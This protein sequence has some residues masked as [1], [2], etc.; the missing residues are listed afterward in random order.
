MRI[1]AYNNIAQVYKANKPVKTNRAQAASGKDEVT[2]SR[3]GRDFQ[4]AKQ[5]VSEAPDIREDKV[6]EAKAK[7]QSGTYDVSSSDFASKLMEKMAQFS[8]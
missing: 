6:A 5:A 7:I 8:A 2:I 1:E 3:A 4:V